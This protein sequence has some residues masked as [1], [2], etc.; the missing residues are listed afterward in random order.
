[1]R[2]VVFTTQRLIA[3]YWT[4]AELEALLAVYGD[5]DAMRW[6]GDGRAITR[7]QCEKWTHVTLA[8]YEKHGYGM[9]ALEEKATG[10][11]IGFCGIV[12]PDGQAEAEVKYAFLRSH[13]GRGLATEAV[14]GLLDY[15]I[16]AHGLG[17]IIA[18]T[19]PENVASH[20]VLLKAGLARGEL[21]DNGD[22]TSTQ[23]FVWRPSA[24]AA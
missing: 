17:Y 10:S 5:I 9:Y 6:V 8:N 7:D 19:A 4:G 3:H 16:Q 13:W 20:R 24:S 23:L 1:M 11:T 14:I 21:R 2:K 12:H 22:G 15:G 18:T